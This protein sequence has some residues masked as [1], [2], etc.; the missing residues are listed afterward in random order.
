M[1]ALFLLGALAVQITGGAG[2]TVPRNA[3]SPHRFIVTVT[4]DAGKPAP[5]VTVT[6][7]LPAEG[8][9]GRF[10]SGLRSESVLSDGQGR[11]TVYGIVWNDLPGELTISVAAATAGRR[12]EATI[13]VEISATLPAPKAARAR[14]P[15]SSRKWVILAASAGAALAGVALVSKG[16][17]GSAVIGPPAAVIVPPSIGTPTITIGRPQ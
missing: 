16:S 4:D 17:S 14:G 6:F 8:P 5:N 13:P 9:S 10:A 3:P 7:R 12:A 15:S 2:A 11:A 1:L